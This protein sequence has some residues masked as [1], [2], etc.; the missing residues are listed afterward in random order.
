MDES[1]TVDS[2]THSAEAAAAS[3]AAVSA[4]AVLVAA[5]AAAVSVAAV[6]TA[7][8]VSAAAAVAAAEL[9]HPPPPVVYTNFTRPAPFEMI[10][11][12]EEAFKVEDKYGKIKSDGAARMGKCRAVNMFIKTILGKYFTTQYTPAQ[13]VLALRELSKYPNVRML[14]KSASLTDVEDIEA[15]RFH[16]EQIHRILTNDSKKKSGSTDDIGSYEQSLYS[17]MA[18]SPVSSNY[19]GSV[20][21]LVSR[22]RL[23]PK[24][25]KTTVMR[26][27]KRQGSS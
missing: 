13:L 5:E 1:L 17:A 18:E 4:T 20:P 7:T 2:A 14:F 23:F 15:L 16:N 24:I 10:E 3:A 22:A 11:L 19:T 8:E 6:V 25:P 26:Y 9:L 27:E 12:D 21:T